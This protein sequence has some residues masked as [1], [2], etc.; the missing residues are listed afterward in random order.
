MTFRTNVL[1]GA[2]ALLA[3]C[4]AT[5]STDDANK[6]E[7]PDFRDGS[8]FYVLGYDPETGEQIRGGA[9]AVV[10]FDES[11]KTE[12]IDSSNR[13]SRF[14]P[15]FVTGSPY[16]TY[17]ASLTAGDTS[18]E[19]F[20][21]TWWPQARNGTAWRWQSGAS[22]DYN[23]HTDVDRLS[24]V[25][26]YDLL[27]YPGQTQVVEAV[28]HCTYEGS[29]EDPENCERIEHPQVTVVGPTTAWELENQGQYQSVEPESWWG[30]CNG[31]ASYA[32]TEP[33]GYPRRDIRVRLTDGQVT[34]CTDDTTGCVLF[35]MADMEALM[36]ELYFSDQATF[37]GRRCNTRPDEI[38]RD[39][40]GRPTEV[41]CRDLNPGS[42][43]TAIVGML[44]RGARNLATGETGGRPAFVIDHNWDHEIWNF[45]IVSY[46]INSQADVTEEE[47]SRLVGATSPDYRWNTAA[48]RFV[49]IQMTYAMIS[50]GVPAHDL[51]TRADL[52]PIDPV[53]VDL[54]YVLELDANGAILGGEWIEDP[55]VSWGENNKE[56]HP[57]FIWMA[58]DPV[59]FG[60]GADDTGGSNDNPYVS[61]PLA[62]AL[63]RCANEPASCRPDDRTGSTL[64]AATDLVAR[65]EADHYD[66][67]VVPPGR[68]II[69]LAQNPTNP[70][71]DA[72]LYVRVGSAPTAAAYDC[73]PYL[74][75]SD[76]RC[77]VNLTQEGRIFVMVQ[78]Y[79]S[80]N[81]HYVLTV[82][83][84]GGDGGGGGE[85]WEGLDESG[86]V[87][88]NQEV[89]FT[90]PALAAGRYRF[91]MTGTADADLYVRLGS[92]PTTST[93]DCRPYADGSAESCEV[94][95]AEGQAV[96][97]MVRGYATTSNFELLGFPL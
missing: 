62:Q 55:S 27:F 96:H 4:A 37:S 76:E 30:H 29:V 46:R 38:A 2:L 85:E 15:D 9:H 12:P 7:T 14:H 91:E 66:T 17:D 65:N 34:E 24:P 74:D 11:G 90:T 81:N 57:D 54:N 84:E 82:E 32:T 33:L 70:G 35:R 89:R 93:W 45:P 51:V 13:V 92:A 59:G 5:D 42:F 48:T 36:T 67:D 86:T 25:E 77:E 21:S 88:R 72:D 69:T 44:G 56:L 87:A 23:V 18:W 20:P 50:D 73:R 60:E 61:Y 39:E 75:G 94:T 83:G 80:T 8:Y 16:H 10:G 52:R 58:T 41:A 63:L 26:K 49:R 31:W 1:F 28:S 43:H 68:Y 19:V 40:F 22:Q 53:E 78:G 97:V 71:G 79:A 6:G 3:G 64:I 95:A 47:A